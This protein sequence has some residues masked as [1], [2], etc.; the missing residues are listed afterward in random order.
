[1]INFTEPKLF[2]EC[3]ASS[4]YHFRLFVDGRWVIEHPVSKVIVWS[5]DPCEVNEAI[6]A[7]EFDGFEFPKLPE[8]V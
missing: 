7:A 3:Y 6:E 2:I 4:T 8:L 5:H 1:M